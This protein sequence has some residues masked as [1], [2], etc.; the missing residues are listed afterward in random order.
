MDSSCKHAKLSLFSATALSATAMVGSG[1][2]FSAQLNAK[3]AGN[4]SFLAWILAAL[5]VMAV[6]LCLA[7]VASIYPVRGAT[8]RSSALS[9]NSI[10]GMPFAFANW[11]GLMV[12]IG[13][14]AQAT[15]Q[16]LAAAL[17]SNMLIADNVLTLSGKLF[18][19]SI[20]V[21]YL[22]INYFGIKL[23][24]KI[25]NT[26]TVIKIFSPLF[27]IFIFLI[28]RFDTSNFSL[29]SNSQYGI[30]SAITAIISAGLIYSYNGFQLAVA[31]ASEIKNPK[32]NI[33]LSIVLSIV[34]VMFVYMLLQLSFM[35][36]VPHSM[37]SSG[38]SALNFHSPL[39]NLAMLLGVNFLAMI[40]IADSVV[41]PSGTGYSYLG[42]ASRMFYAMAKEGQMPKKTISKLHPQYNLCRRSLLINFT[43]TAIFLWNSDSWASLMV[44]VTGYHLIGYMAAPISMGA[45]KPSTRFF[46]IIIFCIL[47]IMMS[48]LPANDFLKMNL[49]ISVLMVIYGAVQIARQMKVSTLLVLST[50]FITYLWL[51]YFYQNIYYILVISAIFYL[52]ITHREYVKLCKD[53]QVIADDI[54]DI[55][56]KLN[57]VQQA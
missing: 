3:I 44:I 42:G 23:L 43:L 55:H 36:A 35:G 32:R 7:Q 54:A 13:T 50:P 17:K 26:V 1:W 38:W 45:I 29:P 30:S 10:F 49:S 11:F 21:I 46:G 14:E 12:T 31:F 15:T 27:T 18:A 9:H 47:G 53:T 4:Y 20:L 52:L 41:S 37:L 16:Y 25:N 48:T 57:E 28:M 40:L 34:I 2:L 56:L 19:L 24:A 39:I 22:F 5:L 8:A 6:G 51:I 33:P